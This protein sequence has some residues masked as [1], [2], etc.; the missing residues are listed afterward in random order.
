LTDAIL[1]GV[2]SFISGA[3]VALIAVGLTHVYRQFTD[4]QK[5]ASGLK[6]LISQLK[7]HEEQLGGLEYA[8]GTNLILGGLDPSFMIHFINSDIVDLSRDEKLITA[9]N[10]H[11]DNIESLKRALGRIDL[12]SA[13][14]ATRAT[15]TELEDNIRKAMPGRLPNLKQCL[16]EADKS[17][18]ETDKSLAKFPLLGRQVYEI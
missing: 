2:I 13:S 3:A 11:L 16:K 6:I 5:R 12:F 17:L 14:F 4:L 18:K 8:L 9:L 1:A 7:H 15:G 10:V